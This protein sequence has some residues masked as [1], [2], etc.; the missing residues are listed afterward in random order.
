MMRHRVLASESV[1]VTQDFAIGLVDEI[2]GESS[3]VPTTESTILVDDH[4]IFILSEDTG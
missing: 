1:S 2:L 3:V 4:G